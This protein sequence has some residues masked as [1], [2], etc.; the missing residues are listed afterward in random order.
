MVKG[1]FMVCL[2]VLRRQTAELRRR[3][4][5]A[6]AD[7][8]K[9]VRPGGTLFLAGAR[10]APASMVADPSQLSGVPVAKEGNRPTSWSNPTRIRDECDWVSARRRGLDSERQR[11]GRENDAMV[12]AHRSN[13]HDFLPPPP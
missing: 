1:S 12:A 9:S 4:Q 2:S 6:D 3:M 11:I 10:P 7:L 13:F 5:A 8:A